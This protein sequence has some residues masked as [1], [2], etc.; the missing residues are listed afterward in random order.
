MQEVINEIKRREKIMGGQATHQILLLSAELL[1][2]EDCE[3]STN[4]ILNQ[5]HDTDDDLL[6]EIV[7]WSMRES[8]LNYQ[9]TKKL[10]RKNNIQTL[11]TQINKLTSSINAEESFEETKRLEGELLK[12]N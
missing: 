9:Q 4:D 8:T 12:I 6:F 2:V 5:P 10:E 11:Q 1:K 7:L 3:V